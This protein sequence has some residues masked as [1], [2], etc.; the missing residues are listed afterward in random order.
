MKLIE[1]GTDEVSHEE[2]VVVSSDSITS[3]VCLQRQ[4]QPVTLVRDG[5]RWRV[6]ETGN[7]MP[8]DAVEELE[9]LLWLYKRQR[10]RKRNEEQYRQLRALEEAQR[11]TAKAN[12]EGT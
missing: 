4:G 10:M 12:R 7:T 3:W 5:N 2:R 8:A 6:P 1:V 11:A 9:Q